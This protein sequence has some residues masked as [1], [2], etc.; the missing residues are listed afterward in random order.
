[1]DRT[2]VLHIKDEEMLIRIVR[3]A[4][5]RSIHNITIQY[6]RERNPAAETEAR[7]RL[8]RVLTKMAAIELV[9]THVGV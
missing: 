4:C 6:Y 8:T 5:Y 9:E 7:R 3:Y 1:M 2:P